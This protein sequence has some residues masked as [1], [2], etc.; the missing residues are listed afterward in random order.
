[1][2]KRFVDQEVPNTTIARTRKEHKLIVEQLMDMPTK[3]VIAFDSE[4]S[5]WEE[6]TSPVY[7]GQ[8]ISLQFYV[9]EHYDWGTGSRVFADVYAEPRSIEL[10]APVFAPKKR[11]FIAHNMSFDRQQM[12]NNIPLFEGWWADTMQM[13]RLLYSV[14]PLYNLAFLTEKYLPKGEQRKVSIKKLFARPRLKKDGTPY[15]SGEADLPDM[16]EVQLDPKLFRKWVDYCCLDVVSLLALYKVLRAAL[17]DTPHK[18]FGNQWEFYQLFWRPFGKTLSS[19]ERRGVQFDSNHARELLPMVTEDIDKLEKSFKAWASTHCPDAALMNVGSDAQKQTLIFGG[20]ENSSWLPENKGKFLPKTRK[21][22]VPNVHGFIKEGRSKPNKTVEIELRSMNLPF[23]KDYSTKTGWPK[24]GIAVMQQLAGS[25]LSDKTKRRWGRAYKHFGGGKEGARACRAFHKLAVHGNC[26]QLRANFIE[27]LP[28]RVDKHGR[29]HASIGINAKTGRISSR[30]PNL[31]NLPNELKDDYGVRDCFISAP[32]GK[33][34]AWDGYDYEDYDPSDEYVL[35]VRDFDQVELRI[36]CHSSKDKAMTAGFLAGNDPHSQTAY[37]MYDHVRAAVDR[38]DCLI[39]WS[40]P[41]GEA[42]A[43]TIKEMFEFERGR[44]KTINF[45][46]LYGKSAH[47]FAV[48]WGTTVQEAQRY[49]DQWFAARPGVKRWQE[50]L[51]RFAQENGYVETLG[52]RRFHTPDINSRTKSLRRAQE[53][54]LKNAPVQGG[55]A[56]VVIAAMILIENDPIIQ[57]RYGARLLLQVHDELV[58]EVPRKHVE[59][60]NKRIKAHMEN[61]LGKPLRVPLTT[62]GSYEK[63]YLLAK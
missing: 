54:R 43:P 2:Q 9:G 38:G 21:F 45:S 42:P 49:I 26:T 20:A 10:Y 29:I 1:M 24:V 4:V 18:T 31:T 61:P 13:A 17:M 7:S 48:D 19:M 51:V 12:L 23:N 8:V 33:P 15:A 16:L 56:D 41:K 35:L 55:A 22:K 59:K 36:A 34:N 40:G 32:D 47:G 30:D 46:V 27:P 63:S 44:S 62:S 3:R 52:G 50:Y 6:G 39:D 37:D 11:R 25:D 58:F 60:A 57:H 28:Q 53:R 14:D 5:G